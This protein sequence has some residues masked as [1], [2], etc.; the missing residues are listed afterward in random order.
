VTAV[1]DAALDEL[2]RRAHKTELLPLSRVLGVNPAG[3]GFDVLCR[4]LDLKL[5]QVGQLAQ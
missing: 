3:L 1:P 4:N 2:L 5:R